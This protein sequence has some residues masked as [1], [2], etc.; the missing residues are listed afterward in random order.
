V[1]GEWPLLRPPSSFRGV[2]LESERSIRKLVVGS[3]ILDSGM[4]ELLAHRLGAALPA[5]QEGMSSPPA[6]AIPDALWT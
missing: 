1:R 3:Q 5:K 6:C 4:I 2:R